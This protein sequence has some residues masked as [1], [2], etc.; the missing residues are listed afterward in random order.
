MLVFAISYYEMD[1]LSVSISE[2]E[3]KEKIVE[4][5]STQQNIVREIY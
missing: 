1:K 5:L 4:E 3:I 2:E